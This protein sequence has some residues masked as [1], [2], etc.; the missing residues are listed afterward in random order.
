MNVSVGRR[1]VFLKWRTVDFDIQRIN[2]ERT[3][4]ALRRKVRVQNLL[5]VT[6]L[7]G[8]PIKK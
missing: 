2:L 8:G 1:N 6:I 7:I 3:R 5:L 4:Y